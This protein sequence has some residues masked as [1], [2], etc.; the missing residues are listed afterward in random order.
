MNRQPIILRLEAAPGFSGD[1]AIVRAIAIAGML[2][3][4][5]VLSERAMEYVCH[6]GDTVGGVVRRAYAPRKKPEYEA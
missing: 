5:V 1:E 3:A 4:T 6:P 2:Q